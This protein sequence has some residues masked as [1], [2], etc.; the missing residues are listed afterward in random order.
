MDL[1]TDVLSYFRSVG[2][3]E[4]VT[5]ANVGATTASGN[6][7]FDRATIRRRERCRRKGD[8]VECDS[9]DEGEMTMESNT[10]LEDIEQMALEEGIHDPHI[11]KAIFLAGGGGSGK[12]FV[13][14]IMFGT[15]ANQSTTVLGL[16]SANSDDVLMAM[17]GALPSQMHPVGGRA[18]T[19]GGKPGHSRSGAWYG[20]GIGGREAF[21]V[22]SQLATDPGIALRKQAKSLH[23]KRL[24]MWIG[25]RLG[26]IIDGT[27][28]NADKVLATRKNLE[29]NGYDTYM[30]FVNTDL[31]VALARNRS[32]QRVVPE[33]VIRKA[34]KQTQEAARKLKRAFGRN[35]VEIDNSKVASKQDIAKIL[36][37]KFTRIAMKFLKEPVKNPEGR[38][39]LEQQTA[40][41][42]ASMKRKIMG[43]PKKKGKAGKK[44]VLVTASVLRS[45]N[46]EEMEY[47]SVDSLLKS[48]RSKVIKGAKPTRAGRLR[49]CFKKANV[50]IP[51]VGSTAGVDDDIDDYEV[52]RTEW[53]D[54]AREAAERVR[55]GRKK[56]LRKAQSP[57]ARKKAAKTRMKKAIAKRQNLGA[58]MGIGLGNMFTEDAQDD[59][60]FARAMID[61]QIGDLRPREGL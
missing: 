37:P 48:I 26:L 8:G 3:N 12:G 29:K 31:D 9:D 61:D 52:M 16:K 58:D 28:K 25:Q 33:D 17:A 55:R 6:P 60:A 43:T 1:F 27:A 30:V 50:P 15:M 38:K 5:S 14:E 19:P 34:H 46:L 41:L 23:E 57:M 56:G 24:D 35:F 40:H 11:L 42:P 32:R 13:S 45:D 10:W 2:V 49:G 20:G 53:T 18:P 21:D 51:C 36:M 44:K 54:E 39:W 22:G 4:A 47:N 59:V 7:V